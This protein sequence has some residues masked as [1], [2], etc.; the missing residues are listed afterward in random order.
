MFFR[1]VNFIT[2]YQ[3]KLCVR[4]RKNFRFRQGEIRKQ[5]EVVLLRVSTKNQTKLCVLVGFFHEIHQYTILRVKVF[6]FDSQI[7]A[8]EFK[9]FD[10]LFERNRE[11]FSK[12][13]AKGLLIVGHTN[14]V[15]GAK[16]EHN[17]FVH[18]FCG[19]DLFRRRH[20]IDITADDLKSVNIITDN[21]GGGK[22]F[23]LKIG[24]CACAESE[25]WCS[26]PVTAVVARM[27]SGKGE[28]GDF[29]LLKAC[30]LGCV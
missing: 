2:K 13:N 4:E 25:I 21:T 3:T 27:L 24:M 1:V 28:V 29:V 23:I 30:F 20:D 10:S 16:G 5:Y 6:V 9:I 18:T 14:A 12:R 11:I 8:V 26:L 15:F 7:V 22:S 17:V 19:I